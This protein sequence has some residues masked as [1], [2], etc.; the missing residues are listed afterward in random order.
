MKYK[1]TGCEVRASR[2]LSQEASAQC[3]EDQLIK[4]APHNSRVDSEEG[5]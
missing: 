4:P 2:L 5:L 1:L 3:H